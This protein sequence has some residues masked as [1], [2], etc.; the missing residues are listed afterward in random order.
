VPKT[1]ITFALLGIRQHSIGFSRFLKLLFRAR[2]V[3]ILVRMMEQGQ[4]TV[5]AF[6]FLIG[7]RAVDTQNFVIISFTH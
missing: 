3:W 5:G 4:T 1:I 6:Y 7:G 2:V